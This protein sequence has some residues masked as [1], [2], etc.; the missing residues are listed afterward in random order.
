MTSEEL[1][2]LYPVDEIHD[3]YGDELGH[4]PY[5]PAFF[6]ALGT[7]IARKAFLYATPPAKVVVL[8]CDQTLWRGVCAEDGPD[9][10]EV[11]D[12]FRQ[13]QQAMVAQH[14]GGRLLCLCS[15]NREEDVWAVFDHRSEM[16]LA[17]RHLVSS[18]LNWKPKSENLK[19]LAAELDLGL[20]SFVFIDDNPVECAEVEAACPEVVV[21]RLPETPED[22]PFFLR[23]VWSLDLRPGTAEDGRRTEMYR[24][25]RERERYRGE[26]TSMAEFLA[27][28][29]LEVD[30]AAAEVGQ[31]PRLAQLLNAPTNSI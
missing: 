28:L 7:L 10:V 2:D 11:S 22:I 19:E 29:E 27:G 8:D 5:T 25:A 26:S 20:D 21:L 13:L 15:K 24:E 4:L 23:H 1:L 9:G 30:I 31:L 14:D 6:T 3:A 17:R 18:R 12:P 16:P